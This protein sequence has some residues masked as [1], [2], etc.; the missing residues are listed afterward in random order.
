MKEKK[1]LGKFSDT[2]T[3]FLRILV[4]ILVGLIIRLPL[5]DI[6]FLIKSIVLFV[7]YLLIRFIAVSLTFNNT[8]INFKERV[9][10]ALNASKGVALAVVVFTLAS[11]TTELVNLKVLLDLSLLF[12]FYTIIVASISVKFDSFFLNPRNNLKVLKK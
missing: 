7:L 5:N 3:H 10:M 1:E 2:F 4:F 11:F 12:I 6:E 9:F 8:N